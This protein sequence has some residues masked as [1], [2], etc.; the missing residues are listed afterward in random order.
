[1][2][3]AAMLKQAR[4][5]TVIFDDDSFTNATVSYSTDLSPSFDSIDFSGIGNGV[6][7]YSNNWGD[8]YWGGQGSGTP[9]RTY[10]PLEK[11]RCRYIQCRIQHNIAFEK[12]GIL[13]NS[14]T[15]ELNSS[16]AYR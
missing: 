15:Y 6:Y 9:F 12:Y 14:Y 3:D 1:L 5:S 10:V 4:E 8:D 11:Q 16:K 13:G 7:G 2:Y